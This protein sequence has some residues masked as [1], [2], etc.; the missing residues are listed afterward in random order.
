MPS[1]CD[2]RTGLNFTLK[3]LKSFKRREPL[4]FYA[5]SRKVGTHKPLYLI[6]INSAS[7]CASSG[8]LCVKKNFY[9]LIP[10]KYHAI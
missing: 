3:N 1:A 7:L 2:K 5:D 6:I 10:F 4:R 9:I 8:C